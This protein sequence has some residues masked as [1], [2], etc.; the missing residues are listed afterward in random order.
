MPELISGDR[1]RPGAIGGLPIETPKRTFGL[2]GE[3][4]RSGWDCD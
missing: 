2:D 1:R 3:N 4:V